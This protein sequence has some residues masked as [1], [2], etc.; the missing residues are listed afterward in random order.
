MIYLISSSKELLFSVWTQKTFSCSKSAIRR[1]CETRSYSTIKKKHHNDAIDVV[2]LS[3]IE[4]F[5]GL[6]FVLQLLT[7]SRYF[8]AEKDQI[9]N[10][11]SQNRIFFSIEFCNYENVCYNTFSRRWNKNEHQIY[12]FNYPLVYFIVYL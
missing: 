5:P 7:L 9:M 8:F 4:Q 6:I 10:K 3:S 11:I 12:N 1:I 2:L